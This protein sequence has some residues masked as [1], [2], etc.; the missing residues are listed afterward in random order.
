MILSRKEKTDE[1][2]KEQIIMSFSRQPN[3]EREMEPGNEE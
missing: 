2:G 3:K 1:M